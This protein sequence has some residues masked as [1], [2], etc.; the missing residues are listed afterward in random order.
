MRAPS[1]VN[2]FSPAPHTVLR[3]DE[4]R[5]RKDEGMVPPR[6]GCESPTLLNPDRIAPLIDA[7]FYPRTRTYD[8]VGNNP[9]HRGSAYRRQDSAATAMVPSSHRR[10]H[11]IGRHA[12]EDAACF[13]VGQRAG[14]LYRAVAEQAPLRAI[15][16]NKGTAYPR[17]VLSGSGSQLENAGR[18]SPPR[19]GK[20]LPRS[21]ARSPGK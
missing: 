9:R 20:K 10:Q 1:E 2:M 6:R 11:T 21:L 16:L 18:S 19:P 5:A 15:R 13:G 8:G 4:S 3:V 12:P 14:C 17:P 7:G